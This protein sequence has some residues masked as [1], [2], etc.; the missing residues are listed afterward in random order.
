MKYFSFSIKFIDFVKNYLTY[1]YYV[2][3]KIP[4]STY[5]N[6]INNLKSSL[7]LR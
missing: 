1:V 6:N 5:Y 4:T 2:N 7:K 3:T